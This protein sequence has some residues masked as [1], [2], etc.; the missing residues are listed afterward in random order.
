M[1]GATGRHTDNALLGWIL[2][3]GLT[4]VG[5]ILLATGAAPGGPGW[6]RLVFLGLGLA[7]VA[8]YGI[9][10]FPYFRDLERRLPQTRDRW[11]KLE[12]E[13]IAAFEQLGAGDLVRSIEHTRDLPER[14]AKISEAA[15]ES[16]SHLAQQI[17]DSSIEVASAADAVNEIA[18]EL[19]AGSSQQ[20]AS[21]VEITA[22]ME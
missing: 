11:A 14:L 18:S 13:L 7:G 21:V 17:Q 10:V 2:V 15:S 6:P 12:R 19:A 1:T 5:F 20:A 22:A 16:L 3:V 9:W 8:S 4:L